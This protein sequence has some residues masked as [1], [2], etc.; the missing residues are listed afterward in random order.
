MVDVLM[1]MMAAADAADAADADD[2]VV[3]V[4]VVA[5]VVADEVDSG[6]DNSLKKDRVQ[7]FQ[8]LYHSS[9]PHR[10]RSLSLH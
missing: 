5:V 6:T 4:V 10:I 8:S 2:D 3:V 7:Q 9:V 1:K